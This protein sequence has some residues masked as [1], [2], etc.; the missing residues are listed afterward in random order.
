MRRRQGPWLIR[1]ATAVLNFISSKSLEIFFIALFIILSKSVENSY[2]KRT[3]HGMILGGNGEKM[4]K[5]KGNVVNPDDIVKL[6]Y[7]FLLNYKF[8]QKHVEL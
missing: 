8:L 1:V 6:F 2:A 3:S 5:S 4:S 7:H